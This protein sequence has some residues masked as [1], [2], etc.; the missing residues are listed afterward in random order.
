MKSRQVKL[1]V[2]LGKTYRVS[3]SPKRRTRIGKLNQRFHPRQNAA[4]FFSAVFQTFASRCFR[5]VKH[6]QALVLLQQLV[7][8]AD[9]LLQRGQLLLLL[10]RTAVDP[11]HV[12]YL[13]P[14]FLDLRFQLRQFLVDIL[15]VPIHAWRQRR[16]NTGITFSALWES[17]DRWNRVLATVSFG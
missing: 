16:D 6:A 11:G 2:V 17:F 15:A 1:G 8:G 4:Q 14:G 7:L 13:L 5:H 10:R 9:L 12:G 3:Y